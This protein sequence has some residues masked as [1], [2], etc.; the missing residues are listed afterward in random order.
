MEFKFQKKRAKEFK[1]FKLDSGFIKG[2]ID[3]EVKWGPLGEITYLRTYSRRIEGPDGKKYKEQ[4]WQTVKRVVE[5]VF[6][7]QKMHC[8]KKTTPWLEDKAKRSAET[9]YRLM[10]DFKFLPPGRG[11]WAMG[12]DY[13][14]ERGG[15]CLNNCAF[16][17]T[18]HMDIDPITP[19]SFLMDMSMLGV[20]VGFDTNG[21][22]FDKPKI[23][24][25]TTPPKSKVKIK[26]PKQSGDVFVVPDTREGWVQAL[27]YLLKGYFL[28]E[29][30]PKGLDVS[31]VRKE[32]EEIK[33]FGGTASGPEPLLLMWDE[34]HKVFQEAIA[35]GV[36]HVTS[37]IITDL[38][39]IIGKCVVSGNV[40]RSSE[41]A[42]GNPDDTDF[43]YLK[44]FMK[45][46]D[47]NNMKTGWRWASNNSSFCHEGMNYDNIVEANNKGVDTGL[48][49][50]EKAR[51]YGR[52]M[53]PPTY[54]DKRIAGVNP[55]G[56]QGLEGSPLI[57]I[58]YDDDNPY[59][60]GGE[61]C[62]LVETFPSLHETYEEYQLTL[63]YAYLYAKT[64]TLIPTH[65]EGTN[66]IMLRNRRIGTSQSGVT[67][68]FVKHGRYEMLNWCDNGYNY[69]K[70]MD[71]IY[72]DWL[73]V[74]MSIKVT[75]VKPS[76]TVSLLPGVSPGIHYDWS[77]YYIRRIR[78]SENDP[79]VQIHKD[80]G[81]SMLHVEADRT[82][83]IE[84]PV[85]V[86]NFEKS[87]GQVSMWEQ[88][89]NVK[90]Y[91]KYWSDNLVSCTIK[92]R[93]KDRKDL[94]TLFETA[95]REVK[96]LSVL[97]YYDPEENEVTEN[98]KELMR[99]A[100]YETITREKYLDMKSKITK[101]DFS[102]YTMDSVSERYCDGASCEIATK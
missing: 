48:L 91:Q 3:K 68:A 18:E 43:M 34:I 9:M 84:Y 79:L 39:N 14:Y 78:I 6:T 52:L 66:S 11:L 87:E 42:L 10:F 55:C 24:I 2:F 72:S 41:I 32:G 27:V 33:S 69:I 44:D 15:A 95:E 62:C 22:R 99:Y 63:K 8:S 31:Q 102:S 29:E 17:T 70:K 71:K 88:L 30:I 85:E 35:L 28:G 49:F 77:Q 64:V 93:E 67:N 20:G 76:G 1:K 81:F 56:E 73:C 25:N 13:V 12:S 54:A 46:P 101:P 90:D 57:V 92:Y 21:A 53:D 83:A 94:K 5:G 100:P 86:P 65:W 50:L 75:S 80:A 61:L 74:P 40:R 7:I 36:E 96:G 19:F 26:N 4:W 60:G 16:I 45:W 23:T 89:Q 37:S 97:P 82:Y 38:M 58:P 51:K 98:T 47:Q 59:A